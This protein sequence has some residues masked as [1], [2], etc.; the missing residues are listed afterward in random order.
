M[1]N[2][3]RWCS[4]LPEVK[5][6]NTM[7]LRCGEYQELEPTCKNIKLNYSLPESEF[8]EHDDQARI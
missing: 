6:L 2:R 3:C 7:K 1:S 8:N 4:D 5:D